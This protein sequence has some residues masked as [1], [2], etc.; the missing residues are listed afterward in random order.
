MQNTIRYITIEDNLLDMIAL[1]KYAAP[2]PFLKE[3]GSYTTSSEGLVAIKEF[4]PDLIFLDIEMP[5]N[6]TLPF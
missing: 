3:T 5:V 2:Y 4:K 6:A 1:A